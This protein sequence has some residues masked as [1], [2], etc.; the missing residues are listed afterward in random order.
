MLL[1]SCTY[2]L[3]GCMQQ[4][5]LLPAG[6]LIS[7]LGLGG[8]RRGRRGGGGRTCQVGSDCVTTGAL[9]GHAATRVTHLNWHAPSPNCDLSG[10]A[11]DASGIPAPKQPFEVWVMQAESASR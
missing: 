3:D 9:F 1:D 2:L 6:L 7:H 11:F 8:G 5:Q 10:P 4:A